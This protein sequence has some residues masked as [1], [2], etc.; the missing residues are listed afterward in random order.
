MSRKIF[1][2][3][4]VGFN[5]RGRVYQWD[6]YNAVFTPNSSI[7]KSYPQMFYFV[8]VEAT[9]IRMSV[10]EYMPLIGAE[11]KGDN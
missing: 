4:V 7:P 6:K 11:I 10:T 1:Y 2:N 3:Q 9:H 5:Y 8:P